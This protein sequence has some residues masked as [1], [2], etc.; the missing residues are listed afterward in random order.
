V[1][2]SCARV[3]DVVTVTRPVTI[4]TDARTQQLVA[5]RHGLV[6]V[7]REA[8]WTWYRWV[9]AGQWWGVTVAR[10]RTERQARRE[11]ARLMAACRERYRR[12]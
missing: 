4:A 11:A 9:M 3:D 8:V 10:P 1:A 12:R 2:V 5:T 7:Q 6:L